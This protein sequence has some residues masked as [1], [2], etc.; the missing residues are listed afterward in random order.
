[1]DDSSSTYPPSASPS[2]SPS[3]FP[4][5]PF[6][7]GLGPASVSEGAGAKQKN[8]S[9][10][11]CT[12]VPP[13]PLFCPSRAPSPFYCL[14]RKFFYRFVKRWSPAIIRWQNE[15]SPDPSFLPPLPLPLCV[16][17]WRWLW[18]SFWRVV[19]ALAALNVARTSPGLDELP[20]W[21][22]RV[23]LTW[24][25]ARKL[26][27]DGSARDIRDNNYLARRLPWLTQ[28]LHDVASCWRS[29]RRGEGMGGMKGSWQF[30]R[31]DQK[32]IW[33]MRE[34]FFK[35]KHIHTHN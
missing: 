32:I 11:S 14:L 16:C 17:T 26:L 8:F 6:A 33:Q 13:P 35:K 29:F 31:A 30:K 34:D 3:S 9:P 18:Q 20:G 28:L 24:G 27:F 12:F 5:L 4:S 1:M 19:V 21:D 2:P 22:A 15:N 25:F 7:I 23:S 10:K